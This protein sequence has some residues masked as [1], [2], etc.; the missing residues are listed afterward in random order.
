MRAVL[1]TQRTG[2][3]AMAV[4]ATRVDVASQQFRDNEQEMGALVRRLRELEER[5][6]RASEE[7]ADRFAARGQL[8][9]RTRVA[10]LLDPGAPVLELA[11]MAGWLQDGGDQ[12]TS[13]PGGSQIA[14]L[15][16]VEGTRCVVVA[17][18]SGINAGALDAIGQRKFERAQQIAL[19]NHL[20][21]VLLVE[22]AGA[23]LLG[24]RVENWSDGGRIF[25]RLARLSAAGIPVITVLHGSATAGGA[26]LPG[27]SD[28][29]IGVR[30]RGFAFLAGP[31]LLAAATGEQADPESL[32]GVAMHASVTGL[33]DHVAEDDADALRIARE[34]IAAMAW[35]RDWIPDTLAAV[36][37]ARVAP[38]VLDPDELVGI[39]SVD[40]RMPV[41]VREVVARIVDGSNLLE[42]APGMG[43]A[44]VCIQASI[45]GHGVGII[46]NNGPIT[47]AGATKATHFIQRC[48]QRGT[49]LVFLQNTTGYMVGVEAEQAGMIKHGSKM[50]QAVAN[51]TVPRIT[52]VIGASYGAGN[53]GMSGQGFDPRFLFSWPNA[54]SGVMGAEQAATT[55]AIV[56][57]A[58][59]QRAGIEVDEATLQAQ[60]ERIIALYRAQESAF[61]TSGRGLD[62]GVID[63][64]DTRDLLGFL[65]ATIAE[66]DAA[67]PTPV[68]FGVARP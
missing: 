8:T 59:A 52:I 16:F 47:T 50:I 5:T 66:G 6:E 12:D 33:V 1:T 37:H 10:H 31:P 13:V 30:D 40:P 34:V 56:A 14:V 39:V 48:S 23:D 38:P 64:R 3:V 49:P 55:M 42:H 44:T 45:H 58:R 11:T 61:V 46:G 68:T 36:D 63:P 29:V 54:R 25:A 60:Q 19:D 65:L 20:P 22:S 51:A 17:N 15:G 7:S 27:L 2:R 18:D 41:D 32:G 62:D 24:Y 57:R 53:Y 67:T 28:T 21:L 26:Y 43:S 9:P 4:F 35:G